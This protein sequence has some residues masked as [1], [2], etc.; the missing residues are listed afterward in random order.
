MEM[1]TR[2]QVEHPVTEEL[3]GV[4]LVQWQI[5]VA[6]GEKLPSQDTIKASGHVIELR[7]CAE[8]PLTNFSGSPEKLQFYRQPSDVRVD[9][10][11]YEGFTIPAEF[12]S[13][14]A[15]VIVK[16]ETRTTAIEAALKAAR[17]FHIIGPFT[18]LDY[19]RSILKSEEFESR[20]F[21]TNHID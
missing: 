15:K 14:I 5:N 12:D 8:N 9:T 4:D 19:I 1:N 2:L 6:Q 11:V 18:N 13:M 3:T 20:S 16:G 7:V 17:Q 21:S 10:G